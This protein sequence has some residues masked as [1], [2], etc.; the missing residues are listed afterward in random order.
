[1][2]VNPTKGLVG[3]KVSHRPRRT[4]FPVEN[5]GHGFKRAVVK[6]TALFA[7]FH[8]EGEIRSRMFLN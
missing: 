3:T 7:E 5:V 1:M 6:T 4:G 8:F 2:P